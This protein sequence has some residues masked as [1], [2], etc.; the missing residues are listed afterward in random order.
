MATKHIYLQDIHSDHTLWSNEFK[1]YKE[2]IVLLERRLGEIAQRNNA[3]E[4][5]AELEHFQN[6]YIRQSEVLDELAHDV[7]ITEQQ[8]AQFAQQN[9]TAIDHKYFDEYAP[10]HEKLANRVA[11][12]RTIYQELKSDLHKFLAKWM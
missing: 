7:K 3:K 6:Q 2:E 9:E 12:F 8:F 4:V 10:L 11:M 5:M 1:F